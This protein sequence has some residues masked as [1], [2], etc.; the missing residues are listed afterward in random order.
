LLAGACL[1][2]Q[3]AFPGAIGYSPPRNFDE[4]GK[5]IDYSSVDQGGPFGVKQL[6]RNSPVP[7]PDTY[8]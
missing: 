3:N 4:A 2:V 7:L 5:R 6:H 8:A 1:L